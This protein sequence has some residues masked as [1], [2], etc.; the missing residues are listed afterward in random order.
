[1]PYN[2][3]NP[4]AFAAARA[5]TWWNTANTHALRMRLLGI[6]YSVVDERRTAMADLRNFL[7][8]GVSGAM[9]FGVGLRFPDGEEDVF[10]TTYEGRLDRLLSAMN[11]VLSFRPDNIAKDVAVGTGRDKD[12]NNYSEKNQEGQD[13]KKRFEEI[14]NRLAD[15]LNDRNAI[16]MRVQFETRVSAIW[17]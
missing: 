5:S 2:R 16:W 11:S 14:Q 7:Q 4:E 10:Y 17:V 9:I 6:D 15:L 1:M 8:Q 13:H 12:N 3:R